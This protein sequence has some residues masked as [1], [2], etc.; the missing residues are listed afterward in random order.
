ME[1][2]V[3]QTK[4]SG[5]PAG[6]T[7]PVLPEEKLPPKLGMKEEKNSLDEGEAVLIWPE[8]LSQRAFVTWS[9]GSMGC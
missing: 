2:A 9:I 1:Q 3:V 5:L 7:P 4:G 8:N 6:M